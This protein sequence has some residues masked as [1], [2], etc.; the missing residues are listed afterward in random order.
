M[1]I[2]EQNGHKYSREQFE[3]YKFRV[4]FRLKVSDDWREDIVVHIYTDN[5]NKEEVR[6]TI[7]S[8]ISDKVIGCEIEHWT[9]KEQD[10]LTALFIE[11]TL[12]GI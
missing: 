11:E 1:K 12:K 5:S 10:E 4:I 3:G 8:R 9:T 7:A 6:D 2:L